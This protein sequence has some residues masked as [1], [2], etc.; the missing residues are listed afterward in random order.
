MVQME[1]EMGNFH[2]LK[3]P[4]KNKTKKQICLVVS[5]CIYIKKKK[6]RGNNKYILK[7]ERPTFS[8]SSSLSCSAWLKG[9]VFSAR[10]VVW[11]LD[12]YVW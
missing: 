4:E 7:H 8:A 12:S 1:K 2:L 3:P 11:T 9:N 5:D 6:N 10:E